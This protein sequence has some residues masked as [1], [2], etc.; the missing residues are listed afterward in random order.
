MKKGEIKIIN[1]TE[2]KQKQ[3][4]KI[5]ARFSDIDDKYIKIGR[6]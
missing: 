6:D 2:K 5:I 3:K 1:E 4:Q